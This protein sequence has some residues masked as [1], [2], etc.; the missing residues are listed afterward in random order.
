MWYLKNVGYYRI[1]IYAKAY[2]NSDD[3]FQ[4]DVTFDHLVELYEF[5]KKLRSLCVE[6]LEIIENSFKSALI[7]EI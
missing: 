3:S 4:K 7:R 6:Y 5:D 2:Q 1:S